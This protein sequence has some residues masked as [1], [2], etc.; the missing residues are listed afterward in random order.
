[1]SFIFIDVNAPISALE[2]AVIA[3]IKANTPLF[4][5]CDVGKSSS[6]QEGVM[7]TEV[8]DLKAAYGFELGMNKAQRLSM[9]ESSVSTVR[10]ERIALT[11]CF[12]VC[13][14]CFIL[15]M[16]LFLFPCC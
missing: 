8:Y 7:D 15:C 4:F 5:G 9:G 1:M 13:P 12:I 16:A 11:I 14:S 3:G 2:D 10:M 6:T